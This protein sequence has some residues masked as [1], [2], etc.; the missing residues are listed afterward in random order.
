MSERWLNQIEAADY[1]TVS[2]HFLAK[3][4][5]RSDGPAYVVV[6][7]KKGIRYCVDDLDAWMAE[8]R[9]TGQPVRG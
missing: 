1:L 9:R 3:L 5:Q 2:T 6:G 8:R 4:R 7:N